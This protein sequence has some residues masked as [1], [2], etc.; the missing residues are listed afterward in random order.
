MLSGC[1]T[2][3][4]GY[5]NCQSC[6]C[7]MEGSKSTECSETGQCNC[8]AN[9]TGKTCDRCAPGY[10][11]FPECNVCNC[12]P[13]SKGISCDDQGQ[14]FCKS[15]FGGQKC[16]K[17]RPNFYNYPVCEGSSFL[18]FFLFVTFEW[19]KFFDKKWK[20]NFSSRM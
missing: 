9:F 5:P 3:Y 14:C 16:D 6:N 8:R 2:T 4:F 1:N 11:L 13:G 19:R 10:F 7:N 18:I 20:L 17:C 15:N 12:G